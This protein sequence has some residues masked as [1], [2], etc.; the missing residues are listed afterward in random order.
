MAPNPPF[1]F[2]AVL[3]DP[4]IP[5]SETLSRWSYSNVSKPALHVV[6]ENEGHILQALEYAHSH[7]LTVVVAGGGNAAFVPITKD[8]LYLSLEKFDGIEL[9]DDSQTV[10]FGG[11]VRAGSVLRE[12]AERGFYT[13][14]PSSNSVGMAGFVLGGGGHHFIGLHGLTVD[15]VESFRIIT[16]DGRVLDLDRTATG[17]EQSLFKVLNGAGLGFGAVV[18]ITMKVY[19]LSNLGME[20]NHFV[21]RRLI[22]P[23]KEI[24]AA[25]QALVSFQHLDPK[26]IVALACVNAPP[27]TPASGTPIVVLESTYFGSK[28]EAEKKAAVLFEKVRVEK[29]SMAMTLS[30]PFVKL[31]DATPNTTGDYRDINVAALQEISASAIEEAFHLWQTFTSANEDANRTMLAFSRFDTSFSEKSRKPGEFI[32]TRDR[33]M[34]CIAMTCF[35]KPEVRDKAEDFAEAF[36]DV[37]RRSD[38]EGVHR[39]VLNNMR[40]HT[41]LGEVFEK[42][43]FV[44]IRRVKRRWDEGGLFWCPWFRDI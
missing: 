40:P 15:N 17:E 13:V 3:P 2:P 28:K 10:T 37:V 1:P 26:L 34:A 41:R 14:L 18:S 42:E 39:T 33:G 31:N 29:A 7:H 4:H 38:A 9:D 11:G 43:A 32:G 30:E 25:A 5:I 36:K 44:E 35:S 8:T 20:N 6:P 24:G 23:D 16:A 27:G 12:L 22:F 21:T 19:P